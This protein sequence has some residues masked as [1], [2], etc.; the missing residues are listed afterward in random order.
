M[1]KEIR[2]KLTNMTKALRKAIMNISEFEN[3]YLNHR[4]QILNLI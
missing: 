1:K 4:R 3:K 2:R